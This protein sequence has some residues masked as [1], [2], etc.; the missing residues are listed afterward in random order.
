M[1]IWQDETL[2]TLSQKARRLIKEKTTETKKKED[3][4]RLIGEFIRDV[5][6]GEQ[7]RLEFL[8]GIAKNPVQSYY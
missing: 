5:Q 3:I 1:K 8:R 6:H 2:A 4:V 7:S